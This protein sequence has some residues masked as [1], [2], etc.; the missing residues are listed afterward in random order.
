[1]KPGQ[2]GGGEVL[3]AHAGVEALEA[4]VD[5]VGAVLDGG[6]GTFP[7]AGRRED[8][9]PGG[10]AGRRDLGGGGEGGDGGRHGGTVAREA[11]LASAAV[12]TCAGRSG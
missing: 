12:V 9:R 10:G 1:M 5:G 6:A 11:G 8:F 4:E 7:V 2:V 3:R